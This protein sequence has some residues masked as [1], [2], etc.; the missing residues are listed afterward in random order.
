MKPVLPK[1]K[2]LRNPAV[3]AV[4]S[5]PEGQKV[6]ADAMK[7]AQKNQDAAREVA[8][9]VIPLVV[10]VIVF[11]GLGYWAYTLWKGR[12]EKR[13]YNNAYDPS[14]ISDGEAE[15]KADAIYTAMY[16]AGANVD[17]VAAQLTGLNYNAWI[18]VYNAF[19]NREP[20]GFGAAMNLNEWIADQF[21][22][23]DDDMQTLRWALPG[24]F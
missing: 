16:G 7:S 9:K 2:G 3:A 19:G 15:G 23:D 4:A 10:K 14:N 24:V 13:G 6:I 20:F 12:F 5:S 17:A 8:V 1:N 21:G 18:K 22:G 11:G